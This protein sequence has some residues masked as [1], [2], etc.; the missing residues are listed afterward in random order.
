MEYMVV[1][2]CGAGCDNL[3][4]ALVDS[5]GRELASDRLPD[6]QPMFSF[7]GKSTEEM[8]I[9]VE[10]G[11]CSVDSCE[12]AVGVF[13][14]PGRESDQLG[15]IGTS[16]LRLFKKELGELGYTQEGKDLGGALG[17]TQEA[18]IP[19]P[20]EAGIEYRIGAVCDDD[21]VDLDLILRGPEGDTINSDVLRDAFPVVI[22]APPQD[23]EYDLLV[24]MA[25]CFI[26]PCGFR[27]AAMS[28][29]HGLG[30]GG[31]PVGGTI[32]SEALR[33]GTL[34]LTD[35]RRPEGGLFDSYSIPAAPGQTVIV[36]LQSDDFDTYLTVDGPGG[37]Q[38][39]SDDYDL[40][41][42]HSHI[43]LLAPEEG[44]YKIVVTT[45]SPE[46]AGDY[47]LQITVV[48]EGEET[49]P[50]SLATDPLLKVA[51]HHGTL[52]SGDEVHPEG[53]FFDTYTLQALAGQTVTADLVSE[54]FD[55]FLIV[56][57]WSGRRWAKD[58]YPQDAGH[59][60]VQ[61]QAPE[62]GEYTILV[63]SFSAGATGNYILSLGVFDEL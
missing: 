36:D 44:T 63:T 43:Q 47:V 19:L 6:A 13:G 55:T 17:H 10:M 61:F 48:E 30:P 29:M 49:P 20:L 5:A 33:R 27:V 34:D 11:S 8:W 16:R 23:G 9:S 46:G 21:C 2:Y 1:G 60:R 4:L 12:F 62:D 39:I 58:G 28:R 3:D 31:I 54:V 32:V 14:H 25:V 18:E 45:Y 59:S 40:E 37:V 53:A 22:Y 57:T 7:T 56:E 41:T 51:T 42:G 35:L 50:D 15:D 24:R 26:E 52:D 38:E